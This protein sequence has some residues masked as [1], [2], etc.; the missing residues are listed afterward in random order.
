MDLQ[1]TFYTIG[2][3][4]MIL[5]IGILIGIAIGLIMIVKMVI[6]LKKQVDD[7]VQMAR[8]IMEHPED[9]AVS[10]GS[11]ILKSAVRGARSFF[12]GKKEQA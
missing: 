4:Y 3:I 6:E 7:K 1:N 2:I 8:K 9:Y 11:T 5:N 12:S 10:I